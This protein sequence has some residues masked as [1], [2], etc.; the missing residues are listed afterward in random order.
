MSNLVD[1]FGIETDYAIDLKAKEMKRIAHE[2]R[3]KII[4]A[5]ILH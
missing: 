3:K 5:D 2:K 4:D 1:I